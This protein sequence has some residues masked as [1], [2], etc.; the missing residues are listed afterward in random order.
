M[1]PMERPWEVNKKWDTWIKRRGGVLLFPYF[2]HTA[3][4]VQGTTLD[5]AVVDAGSVLDVPHLKD[6]LVAHV[7][8]TRVK[9]ADSL[10]LSQAFSPHLFRQGSPPGPRILM[11]LLRARLGPSGVEGPTPEM[12]VA[13]FNTEVEGRKKATREGASGFHWRC[14]GCKCEKQATAYKARQP[15]ELFD[16]VIAVG[17]WRSCVSCNLSRKNSQKGRR[18]NA[19]VCRACKETKLSSEFPLECNDATGA[20]QTIRDV[21]GLASKGARRVF[22]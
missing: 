22:H 9:F 11:Q 3:H 10:L 8:L 14:S 7:A 16:N 12:A 1:Y 21:A 6:M 2:A 18:R 15:Q 13:E 19:R 5:A 20:S 4:I 17:C